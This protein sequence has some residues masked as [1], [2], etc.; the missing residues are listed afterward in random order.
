M[1]T[2]RHTGFVVMLWIQAGCLEVIDHT[3]LDACFTDGDCP[4]ETECYVREGEDIH[5]C[6][7]PRAATCIDFH[8]C[9]PPAQCHA[10]VRD[11]GL[12]S[13]STCQAP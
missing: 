7:A 12:C 10:V 1:R 4:C 9:T 6:S 13:Y 3:P 2:L 11:G 8:T 5:R